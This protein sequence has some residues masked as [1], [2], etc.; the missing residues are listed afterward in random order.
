MLEEIKETKK[1]EFI[2]KLAAWYGS[3]RRGHSNWGWAKHGAEYLRTVEVQGYDMHSL[4]AYP[5]IVPSKE[6]SIVVDLFSIYDEATYNS[7]Y[8]MEAGA[9]Y[10]EEFVEVDNEKYQIWVYKYL[11]RDTHPKVEGGDWS[12]FYTENRGISLRDF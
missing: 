7:V 2:P 5:Y 1:E 6:G 4:W 3:L 11:P 10:R 12:K 8:G 9:G